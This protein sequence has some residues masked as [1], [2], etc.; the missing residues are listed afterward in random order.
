MKRPAALHLGLPRRPSPV[1]PHLEVRVQRRAGGD[2]DPGG[3]RLGRAVGL[4]C[5]D[6]LVSAERH[7]AEIRR[8]VIHD[9]RAAR[10]GGEVDVVDD[11]PVRR[12][13][14]VRNVAPR[15]SVA[16]TRPRQ[17]RIRGGQPPCK[18]TDQAHRNRGSPAPQ[19]S[20]VRLRLHSTSLSVRPHAAIEWAN[21]HAGRDIPP[22]L[23]DNATFGRETP[24]NVAFFFSPPS[25]RIR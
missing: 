3:R 25:K 16:A 21:S 17:L 19:S 6:A 14:P 22:H 8:R 7:R 10:D 18:R 23:R 24:N 5:D 4:P 20:S 2:D 9:C 11:R 15:R 1:L 13:V 12:L